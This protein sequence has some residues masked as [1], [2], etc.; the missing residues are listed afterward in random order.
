M[1]IYVGTL[2]N[3]Y[4]NMKNS[5]HFDKW[6]YKPGVWGPLRAPE[7]VAFLTVKYAFSHFSWYFFQKINFQFM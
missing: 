3:I 6:L 7:A 2:Q 1:Y 4:F 5:G